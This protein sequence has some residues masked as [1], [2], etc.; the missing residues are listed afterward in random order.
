MLKDVIIKFKCKHCKKETE[1]TVEDLMEAGVEGPPYCTC[2]EENDK[3]DV[4][5][6]HLQNETSIENQ[7]I[8][9]ITTLRDDLPNRA[10]C[11]GFYFKLSDAEEIVENNACDIFE[12]GYYPYCVIEELKQGIYFFPRN[13]IWYE[14]SLDSDMYVKMNEK[15]KRFN[16]IACFGIG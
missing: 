14:W 13:E 7:S 15:P 4:I 12:E 10:R 2:T 11:V 16:K 8:F 3:L 1:M 9:T 6:T 5:G